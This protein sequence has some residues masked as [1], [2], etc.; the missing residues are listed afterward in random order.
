MAQRWKK[1][2][3]DR[4]IVLFGVPPKAAAKRWN[5]LGATVIASTIDFPAMRRVLGAATRERP[6]AVP[7]GEHR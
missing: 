3:T 1:K 6:I 4:N 7:D 2:N 5:A